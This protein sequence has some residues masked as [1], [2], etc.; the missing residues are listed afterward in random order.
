M[1][2]PRQIQEKEAQAALALRRPR[3]GGLQ[4]IQAACYFRD[5]F[6]PQAGPAPRWKLHRT[7]SAL[8]D[9]VRLVETPGH[10]AGHLSLLV[11]LP[12]GMPI[13]LCGDAADLIENL[14]DEVAPGLCLDD[15]PE[16]ALASIRKLK[17]LAIHVGADLWP[18]HDLA[19][20]RAKDRFPGFYA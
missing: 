13:L 12:K 7:E 10:T 2:K 3:M 4:K 18:N 1:A 19:F 9:G 14:S 20:F 8:V 5:D 16:P 6:L 15:D 17:K 11:E